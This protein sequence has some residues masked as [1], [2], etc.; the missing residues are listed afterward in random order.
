METVEKPSPNSQQPNSAK[1][2]P[3]VPTALGKL[4]LRSAQSAVF[5]SSHSPGDDHLTKGKKH[6]SN[7][8][9]A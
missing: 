1:G 2:F 7:Q 4:L 6:E 5:H 8:L 3:T 9:K